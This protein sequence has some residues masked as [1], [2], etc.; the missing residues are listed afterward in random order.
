MSDQSRLKGAV[1]RAQRRVDRIDQEYGAANIP[2]DHPLYAKRAAA[3]Q[4]HRTALQAFIAHQE[5]R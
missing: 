4:Q 1:T 2:L 3:K 5:G